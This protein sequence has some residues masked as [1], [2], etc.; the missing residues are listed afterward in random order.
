MIWIFAEYLINFSKLKKNIYLIS[1]LGADERIFQNLNFGTY[2]PKFI[3]WIEPQNNESLKEYAIRL[4]AQIDTP[5]PIILGVSFGGMLAIEIAKYID[6]QQVILVSSAK[7]KHEIPFIYRL[8]GQ[9]KLH[10]LMPTALLKH[11]NILT[12]WLFGMTT[13]SEKALLKSI[14]HNTNSTFLKWAINAIVHW[15]NEEIVEKTVHIHGDS[16]HILPIGCIKKVDFGIENGGHLMIF[17]QADAI[18]EFL[19]IYFEAI[20]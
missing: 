14:L 19:K 16:D 9:M 4:S 8:F 11:A 2:E 6:C 17:N 3:H 15:D 7:T 1:G 12:Y 20:Y 13:K 5:Q 18:N 10:K